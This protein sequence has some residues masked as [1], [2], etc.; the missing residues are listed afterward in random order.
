ML[1]PITPHGKLNP[2]LKQFRRRMRY[3]PTPA[4]S[5]MRK[6]LAAAG[7]KFSRQQAFRDDETGKAYIADFW[8]WHLET[9]VECDG[10]GHLENPEKD[11]RRDADFR[12][13]GIRT[14]RI[15]NGRVK[16]LGIPGLR[17]LLGQV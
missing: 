13:A 2:N 6:L 8:L 1:K 11:A 9:V 14:V 12:A 10:Q 15:L 16:H 17:K 5:R 4:E 7:I 3:A